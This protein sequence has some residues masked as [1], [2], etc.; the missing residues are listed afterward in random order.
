MNYFLLAETEFFRLINEA[1]DCNMET[2]YTAFATQVIELC[3]GNLDPNRTI[4]ALAYIEIELQHHPVRNLSEE[5]K[6]TAAYV[7]KALSFVR[8]MQKFLAMPQVPPL[9]NLTDMPQKTTTAPAPALQ[10]T[11]ST[12]DLVELIYGLFEMGCINNGE[13]PLKELSAALYELFGM[14]TKECYRYYSAIKLRKNSSRTYF[15]DKMLTKLNE[16]IRHD[17]ELERMRK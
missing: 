14:K 17:E 16:K 6:E 9:S 12:L 15:L 1:G 4:I 11:G 13:I 2:A 10:W 7:S 8:K 3:S 5:R